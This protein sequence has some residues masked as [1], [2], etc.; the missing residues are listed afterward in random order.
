[1]IIEAGITDIRGTQHCYAH[2][3]HLDCWICGLT[4]TG[5]YLIRMGCKEATYSGPVIGYWRPGVTYEVKT[6]PPHQS[7][8]VYAIVR[9]GPERRWAL[10][11]PESPPGRGFLSLAGHPFCDEIIA[12]FQEMYRW[13]R[14]FLS[15]SSELSENALERAYLLATNYEGRS[16][17]SFDLRLKAVHE[18][19]IS[20]MSENLTVDRLAEI[21]RLSP[22]RLAHLF[23]E[24]FACAPMQYVE[25]VRMIEAGALLRNSNLPVSE[26]ARRVGYSNQFYFST[27]FA[28]HMKMSPTR[29]RS[30]GQ[31]QIDASQ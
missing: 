24:V 12:S 29:Y 8:S 11:L 21:A 13:S 18:H 15:R 10:Q 30:G 25:R 4:V 20:N 9:F 22:S 5:G 17:G 16:I 31:M 28:H 14:T 6:L 7:Y 26:V 2:N 23:K 27:R 3:R 1:M 19:I